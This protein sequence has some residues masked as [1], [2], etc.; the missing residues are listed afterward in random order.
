MEL[1]SLELLYGIFTLLNVHTRNVQGHMIKISRWQMTHGAAIRT[2]LP[3]KKRHKEAYQA[4]YICFNVLSEAFRR[5]SEK[6]T[7]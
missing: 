5:Y 7:F 6:V 1:L 2:V 3:T 4:P